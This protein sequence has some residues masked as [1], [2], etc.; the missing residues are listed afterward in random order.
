M[1]DLDLTVEEQLIITINE[2]LSDNQLIRNENNFK[3]LLD[4]YL[5]EQLNEKCVTADVPSD[6]SCL[7]H[8][9]Q[10]SFEEKYGEK[11]EINHQTMRRKVALHMLRHQETEE[12][13]RNFEDSEERFKNNN[14]NNNNNNNDRNDR[15]VNIS[16]SLKDG[17][18]QYA[19][20]HMNK[21]THWPVE[22]CIHIIA[23][24]YGL[25]I[26][27]LQE[28]MDPD[29]GQ[30]NGFI[31]ERLRTT[32][33]LLLLSS[34]T[35]SSSSTTSSS[36]SFSSSSSLLLSSSSS[37]SFSSSSS[38]AVT[39]DKEATIIVA[40]AANAST[41]SEVI[42]DTTISTGRKKTIL[43]GNRWNQHYYSIGT[44]KTTE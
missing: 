36:S 38:V 37:S 2:S 18:V 39:A 10:Q 20:V 21:T 23:L 7:Y 44:Y 4:S 32:G 12:Y 11:L 40:A 35:S 25:E 16:S 17:Y 29:S 33:E 19:Q 8:A 30:P 3:A 24:L 6:G 28:N 22:L 43:I 13:L 31:F 34:S 26:I 1:Q 42:R 15:S 27:V 41:A 9:V 14:S 5:K